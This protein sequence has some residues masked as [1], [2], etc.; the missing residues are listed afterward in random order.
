MIALPLSRGALGD[1]V[2]G[3]GW[4]AALLLGLTGAVQI[5]GALAGSSD[6]LRPL[7]GLRGGAATHPAELP[8]RKIKSSEDLDREIA[9]AQSAGRP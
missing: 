2:R 8:F 9:A 6:P 5:V 4:I 7:A 1:G 3:L